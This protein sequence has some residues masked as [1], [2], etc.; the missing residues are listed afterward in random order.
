MARAV[1]KMM[2]EVVSEGGTGT[3]AKV[4]GYR[5]AGKTGTSRK[6]VRGGYGDEY[7]TVFAGLVP[8]SDPKFAIVVMVDEPAGDSYYGGTVS[9]P[10]FSK[11]ADKA[12]H[13]LNI[14]P[15]NKSQKHAI[16][17]ATNVVGGQH[18]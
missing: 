8:A 4:D 3:Q 17:T 7:V 16:A 5:V 9:A 6:A 18:D 1:V 2:E 12:L 10:V 11:V 14:A 15:D 13:L